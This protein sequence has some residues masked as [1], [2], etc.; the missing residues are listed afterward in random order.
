MHVPHDFLRH[1]YSLIFA[2]F[3]GYLPLVGKHIHRSSEIDGYNG[4]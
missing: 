1:V 2:E 4:K 3:R